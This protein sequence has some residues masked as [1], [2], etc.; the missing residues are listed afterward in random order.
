M[1]REWADKDYYSVLGVARTASDKEI[2]KAFRK[3]AQKY[4]PD[5]NPDDASAEA[6]FKDI[7]EANEV[8][9]DPAQRQEYDRFRDAF[10]RGE[11]VG[12]PGGGA[13]YVRMEDLGDLFGGSGA[14]SINDLL[15]SVF[16]R[17][18]PRATAGHDVSADISLT[19]HE[20]V[21]GVTRAVS[22]NG[23]STKVKLPAGVADGATVKV[24]GKGGPGFN[25]GPPGDLY[26]RVKVGGHPIFGRNGANLV[27]N[28]PISYTEAAL[29][30]EI[31]VPT[32]DGSVRL[33]VP[34]GTTTGKT[35]RVTGKGITTTDRT[36]DLMVTVEVDVP[37][38]LEDEE[39]ELLEQLRIYEEKRSP[40][41]H[42][43]LS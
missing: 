30:A 33:K 11:F 25:G 31:A 23:G 14:G 2:K 8:L 6:K 22:H 1:R 40:R 9:G 20:A 35:F 17:S 43:G 34:A 13:Q 21:A 12:G 29:G 32:L 41:S 27:V 7:N 3:L 37:D 15:G 19:F 4:H 38:Q 36:G 26:V 42:L 24:R 16:G 10:A 39:K 28:V 5:A 18:G